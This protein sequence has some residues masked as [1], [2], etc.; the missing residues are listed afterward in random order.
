M[1]VRRRRLAQV[2]HAS[3][4]RQAVFLTV[5]RLWEGGV[6]IILRDRGK[7][8]LGRRCHHQVYCTF[9]RREYAWKERIDKASGDEDASEDMAAPIY[10][11]AA[12]CVRPTKPWELDVDS[13][14]G[15][16]TRPEETLWE[17]CR[18]RT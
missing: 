14:A 4:K 11:I 16:E 6:G 15:G 9:E 12:A 17:L 1:D 5:K 8:L 7:S 2:L 10:I 13:Y 3:L 18:Q